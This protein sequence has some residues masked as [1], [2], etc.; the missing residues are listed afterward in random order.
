MAKSARDSYDHKAIPGSLK[1]ALKTRTR[2]YAPVVDLYDALDAVDELAVD[3][4]EE[5]RSNKR[6]YASISQSRA[7]MSSASSAVDS[8]RGIAAGT[9]HP[10]EGSRPDPH[11]HQQSIRSRSRIAS[12]SPVLA[13]S[14]SGN[15]CGVL[16]VLY[17]RFA[18]DEVRRLKSEVPLLQRLIQRF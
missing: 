17:G 3:P 6:P 8:H 4:V 2:L 15:P 12:A 10:D 18:E 16:G 1:A 9:V 14:S 7:D 13:V 5:S 11:S